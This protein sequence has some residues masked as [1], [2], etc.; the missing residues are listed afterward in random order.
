MKR[1]LIITI[2]A[3][4]GT[5]M[6]IAQDRPDLG[7]QTTGRDRGGQVI[8]RL[9]NQPALTYDSKRE[10]IIVQSDGNAVMYLVTFTNV[11]SNVEVYTAVIGGT[12]DEID[13]SMLPSNVLYDITLDDCNG[14]IY[15]YTFNGE[16]LGTSGPNV[17]LTIVDTS[18]LDALGSFIK[19]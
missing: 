9:I 15:H 2:M 3:A 1:V 8:D 12:Y 11:Q 17:N 4:I 16:A 14:H 7:H 18:G 19:K 13:V 5:L 10:I 6:A